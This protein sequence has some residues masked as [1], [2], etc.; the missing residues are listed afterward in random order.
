MV[1]GLTGKA[2]EVWRQLVVSGY[3]RYVEPPQ[4]DDDSLVGICSTLLRKALLEDCA[5]SDRN[6]KHLGFSP[7]HGGLGRDEFRSIKGRYG[8]GSLQIVI[9]PVSPSFDAWYADIDRFNPLQD[10][11]G[12]LAHQFGAVI[13]SFF[14]DLWRRG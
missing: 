5:Q 14:R 9:R 12:F 11:A 2:R 3:S 4:Q 8:P 13:P 10:V 1:V 6:F 7:M